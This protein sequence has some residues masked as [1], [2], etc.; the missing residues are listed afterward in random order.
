MIDEAKQMVGKLG[1]HPDSLAFLNLKVMLI[2]FKDSDDLAN[3][4]SLY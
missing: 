2:S 1:D 3:R 4:D